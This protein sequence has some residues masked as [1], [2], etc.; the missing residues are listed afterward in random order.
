MITGRSNSQ[1]ST[2]QQYFKNLPNRYFIDTTLRS[3]VILKDITCM[4]RRLSVEI[5]NRASNILS[6][7]H[8]HDQKYSLT[9]I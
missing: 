6:R 4:L 1:I 9:L 7:L 2:I 5:F 8:V 3:N